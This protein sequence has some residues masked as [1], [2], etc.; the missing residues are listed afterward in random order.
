MPE[1]RLPQFNPYPTYRQSALEWLGM[2]PA[3]WAEERAKYFFREVDER[4]STGDEQ[5]M[6]VSH[7]TG[8]TPRKQNVTMFMAESNIGH[9]ICRP[10]DLVINTMWAWM[11]ALGVA[12][13]V[14]LVSPS[15]A[16]YRPRRPAA[17]EPRFV[18]YLLRTEP[19][20]SE[21]LCR[22]TGIRKSR[23]RLYPDHF[24]RIPV[25]C[26]PPSEQRHIA[27][28]LDAHGRLVQRYIRN[29]RRLIDVLN[30]RQ[31][32]IIDRLMTRGTDPAAAL[33]PSGIDWL[34]KVPAHWDVLKLKRVAR[35]DP[36]RSESVHLRDSDVPAVFL[37]M[38]RISTDGQIDASD[39]RP[40]RSLWQGFTY[41]RRNDVILAKITPCFQN[42]KGACL[43]QLP[44][45]IGFGTTELIVL[46]AGSRVV[47]EFLRRVTC[48]SAFRRFGVESMTGAAG[49]QRVSLDFVA[50]F[51]APMPPIE[52]QDEIL[53]A[54]S[55]Q[56]ANAERAVADAERGID[57][58][59]EYRTRFI[60]E[61]VTGKIDVR[62]RTA[63]EATVAAAT[64]QV[65][66]EEID[67]ELGGV[68][69]AVLVEEAAD[70]DD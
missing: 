20:G 8:V 57:L 4:S 11:A 35:I 67:E 43:S 47:P 1:A 70:A 33:R 69:E 48:L 64:A 62:G 45:P 3:H 25:A 14:G 23:L 32:R 68:D 15:Y 34:G 40:V 63:P 2:I 18:D 38:E 19:Y 65:E 52:E 50:N 41:F 44:T 53:R 9:K 26:P 59:R 42:G 13:Q 66:V 17:L 24:L 29:R 51:P 37:P 60:S 49:Q 54:V 55:A 12:K 30:E 39:Q 6:S 27:D 28:F 36:S 10:G 22:S 61:V 21:Y 46:R 58:V 5:L 56:L 7:V 31:Q 16:V